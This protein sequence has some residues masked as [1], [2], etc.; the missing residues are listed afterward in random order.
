MFSGLE[1]ERKALHRQRT[2]AWAWVRARGVLKSRAGSTH[3]KLTSS[4]L[5]TSDCGQAEE[6]SS[7]RESLAAFNY[8]SLAKQICDQF[9]DL[10]ILTERLGPAAGGAAT[11]RAQGMALPSCCHRDDSSMRSPDG[12]DGE[13]KAVRASI[14]KAVLP[15]RRAHHGAVLISIKCRAA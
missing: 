11:E 12:M 2:D 10:S 5:L 9:Y 7:W 1:A 14:M 15:D 8:R 13:R 3:A 4:V 6:I